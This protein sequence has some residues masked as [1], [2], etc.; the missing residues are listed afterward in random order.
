MSDEDKNKDN[1]KVSE[2]EATTKDKAESSKGPQFEDSSKMSQQEK[3][4]V[5]KPHITSY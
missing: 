2:A 5:I 3:N 4:E 1:T